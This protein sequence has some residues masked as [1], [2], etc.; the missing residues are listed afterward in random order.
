M[1][2]GKYTMDIIHIHIKWCMKCVWY[3][4]F[5]FRFYLNPK[6]NIKEKYDVYCDNIDVWKI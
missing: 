1:K 3:K 4:V 6:K 5:Y 2:N